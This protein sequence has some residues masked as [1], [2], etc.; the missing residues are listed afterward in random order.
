MNILYTSDNSFFPQMIVSISSLIKFTKCYINIFVI[1]NS[2]SKKN[3]GELYRASSNRVHIFLLDSPKIPTKLI[4]DRGSTSQFYRLFIGD[5]FKN[6]NIDRLIYLDSDTLVTS[7]RIEKL[8]GLDMNDHLLGACLDPWSENY[9][10]IFNLPNNG[11]MFNTGVLLINIRQWKLQSIDEKI[12]RL[13]IKRNTFIQGDQGLLNEI[14]HGNFFI[15]PASYN[16]ISSY[17]DFS[18]DGLIKFRKP[19][20]FYSINQIHDAINQP[21]IVHFTSSFIN[22]RPWFRKCNHPY[23]KQ[24]RLEYSKIFLKKINLINKRFNIFRTIYMLLPSEISISILGGA[25]SYI[26]P[27]LIKLYITVKNILS[28]SV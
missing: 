19:S 18:Y 15:L 20:F 27:Q 17:F 10:S 26:R 9:R 6:I 8:V 16:T 23:T 28:R 25:Q 13:I 7:S 21:V 5:I 12:K 14:F 24:W 11:K 2:I 3:K 4:P 1:C 22:D